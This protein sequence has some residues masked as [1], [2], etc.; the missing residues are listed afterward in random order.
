MKFFSTPRLLASSLLLAVIASTSAQ[1]ETTNAVAVD[2][3]VIETA[4]TLI[5]TALGSPLG[6]EI[7]ESLTTEVGPR[8]AGSEA[9]QRAREWG[10]TLGEKLSFDRV[11]VEP[12]T[13]PFWDRG[14]LQITLTKPYK[15][16]LYGTA[17]GGSGMSSKPIDAPVVY[18]RSIAEIE[19]VTEGELTGKIAFIDGEFMVKSQTGAGYGE[20]NQKRRVGWQHAQRGGAQALVI[21]S[22]GS[23]SHRFPHTGM[24]SANEDQWAKIP[25]IAAAITL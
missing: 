4:K 7:V 8:L 14:E 24:M 5:A 13:M 17:L 15:Q 18:F 21:R 12:F 6:F 22:V 16:D 20:A 19:A 1:T 23:D 10:V 2:T 25:V 3:E 11:S 9:E